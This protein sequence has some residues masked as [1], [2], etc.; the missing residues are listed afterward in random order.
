[1]YEAKTWNQRTLSRP[2]SRLGTARP[3][4]FARRRRAKRNL[5][6][7]TVLAKLAKLEGFFAKFANFWR[8]RSRLYENKTLQ[9]NMRLTAFFKL[10]KMCTLLHRCDLKILP[11]NRFEKIS[12]FC[13]NSARFLQMLQNLQNFAEFPKIQVDNLE[14]LEKC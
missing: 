7:D 8:A 10:Y 11:K 2:R 1:M 5:D 4:S 13:E 14:D 12:N 6:R 3:E 9:E